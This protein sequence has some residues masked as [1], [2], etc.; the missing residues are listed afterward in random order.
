LFLLLALGAAST[1]LTVAL[2]R[3][4]LF[5][6]LPEHK[7]ATTQK[8][9]NAPGGGNDRTVAAPNA[10]P[11][12]GATVVKDPV[13]DQTRPA[14]PPQP[15]EATATVVDRRAG[16]KAAVP[17]REIAGWGAVVDPDGDCPIDP[18]G[19]A[20]TI[21]VPPT[22]HDLNATIGLY[23][24]PRVL[25]EV[26]GDFDIQVKVVGDFRP[27]NVSN[28]AGGLPFNG[29]GIV[30][31]LDGDSL[32][33]LERGAVFDGASFNS[34]AIFERHEGGS[35]VDDHNGPLDAGTAYLRLG[36]RG[37]RILGA[38]SYDGRRWTQL[39]PINSG[40]SGRLKVG[41]AA[42][43]SGSATFTVRFEELSF[44]TARSGAGRR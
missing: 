13:Q 21:T 8:A 17:A 26:A 10:A 31:F 44:K 14:P 37:S 36:R 29:A 39:E 11:P 30:V 22:L 2:V 23:N 6:L 1:A 42:V 5:V 32:I 28:R 25:R 41:V 3:K 33:R 4:V 35:G 24:A 40:W 34:F 15:S 9:G 18:N 12:P 43:N 19:N 16:P 38:T 7:R 20:L 27:G